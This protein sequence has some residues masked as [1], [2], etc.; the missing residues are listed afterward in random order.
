MTGFI[1]CTVTLYSSGVFIFLTQ[2]FP[3]FCPSHPYT[4]PLAFL[5]FYKDVDSDKEDIIGFTPQHYTTKEG[6]L[7]PLFTF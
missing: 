6:L 5:Y 2:F 1:A 3:L 4:H 7:S